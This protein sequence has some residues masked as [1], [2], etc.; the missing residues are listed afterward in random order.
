MSR[1]GPGC[2]AFESNY[3]CLVCDGH[4]EDHETVFES[5][6][7]RLAAGRTVRQAFMPLSDSP[8]LEGMV[9]NGAPGQRGKKKGKGK[10]GRKA[11][12]APVL[13]PEQML[14]AGQITSQEYFKMLED[15]PPA[16]DGGGGGGGGA[17]EPTAEAVETELEQYRQQAREEAARPRPR[18]DPSQAER[19]VR[20]MHESSG[21]CGTGPIAN[22]CVSAPVCAC[23]CVCVCVCVCG[24]C[25]CVFVCVCVCV[26]GSR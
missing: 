19:S 15:T 9:F 3:L 6:G 13:T 17:A 24:V 23:A 11:I 20:L 1:R 18:V 10:G 12:A 25:V 26:T 2:A 5:E 4:Q 21:G 8:E 16:A 22:R 14:E 7:E